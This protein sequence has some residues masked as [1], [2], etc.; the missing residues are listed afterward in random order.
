MTHRLTTELRRMASESHDV[1]VSCGHRFRE[2]DTTHL[3]YDS[4]GNPLYVCDGCSQNLK[5][6]AVRDYFT[7]R[8]YQVPG[9]DA[10]LWR[11]MDFT[12]Y[13]S[14]LSTSDL[15]FTRADCFEDAFEGAKGIRKN[16]EKWDQH[17]LGFFQQAIRNPPPGHECNLSDEEVEKEADRILK[18]L[19]KGGEADR[20]RTFVNCWHENEFESEAMWR[21]YSSYIDNAIAVQ[22]TYGALYA[23][24][25]RDPSIQIGRVEYVDLNTSYVGVNDA[26][27]RKRKSFEHEREVR[28][29]VTD[30]NWDDLGKII[31]V[32]LPVLIESVFSSPNAPK[33]F[34]D[35]VNDVNKKYGLQIAVE[36]SALKEEPFY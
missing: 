26:F 6:T 20:S 14:L 22:T 21:L 19:E 18:D 36:S 28:A 15:C 35:L 24:I 2:G 25:D 29:V 1:C 33:W 34:L 12:K 9:A 8:P 4:E 23:A 32:N 30:F 5:E 13:V 31:P 10:K 3:G 16:K 27:W 17:Y 7:S 11:Y